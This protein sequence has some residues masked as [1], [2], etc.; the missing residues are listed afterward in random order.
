MRLAPGYI[1]SNVKCLIRI[2]SNTNISSDNAYDNIDCNFNLIMAL[3]Q[4]IFAQMSIIQQTFG[5][6]T[7]AAFFNIC[8]SDI[9]I[10]TLVQVTFVL[11]PIDQTTFV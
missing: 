5:P 6:V 11:L 1:W 7:F 2:C 10:I 9:S 4:V 8:S 3:V